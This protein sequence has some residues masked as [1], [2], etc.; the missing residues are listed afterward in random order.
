VAEHESL[1]WIRPG[2]FGAAPSGVV[3][4]E[5]TIAAVWNL[6]GNVERA[7]FAEAARRQFEVALPIAPNTIVKTDTLT[8][9]W[10]GPRSWLLIAGSV[11]RLTDFAAKRD[12][13]NAAR[14]GL[15]DASASRIAWTISG[16]HAATVLAKGCPLDFHPYTFA[17]GTCAQSVLGHVNALFVRPSDA[18]VFVLMVARS[19]AR[20][21]WRWLLE[22]ASQYGAEVRSPT[23]LGSP[24]SLG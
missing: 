7:A 8:A 18:P 12:A 20:D 23:A 6:Q 4:A 2:R 24:R 16:T 10:A 22:A 13:M 11:S 17:A 3:L 1:P 9:L 14:G 15:F 21:A 19:F 5:A